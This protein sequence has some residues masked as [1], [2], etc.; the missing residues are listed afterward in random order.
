MTLKGTQTAVQG[1]PAADTWAAPVAA[2]IYKKHLD[3]FVSMAVE[4]FGIENDPADPE[5]V[6][7][8]GIEALEHHFFDVMKLPR[9]LADLGVKDIDDEALR[10]VVKKNFQYG[11]ATIGGMEPLGEEDCFAI[12]KACL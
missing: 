6:A 2:Q 1:G 8:A 10:V 7:L 5:K 3:K 4:I 12:Y 11:N 9:T